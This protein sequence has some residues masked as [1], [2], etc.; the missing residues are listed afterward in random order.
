[1]FACRR[2]RSIKLSDISRRGVAVFPAIDLE[3]SYDSG[4]P[5]FRSTIAKLILRRLITAIV[6]PVAACARVT[7]PFFVSGLSRREHC[8]RSKCCSVYGKLRRSDLVSNPCARVSADRCALGD[9]WLQS[10]GQKP[11]AASP[12]LVDTIR[13]DADALRLYFSR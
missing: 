4:K 5:I 13:S 2:N 12:V 9:V 7:A 8:R 10:A 11:V 3:T 6:I 1:M